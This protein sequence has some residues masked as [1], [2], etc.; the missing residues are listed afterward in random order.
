KNQSTGSFDKQL[1]EQLLAQNINL[2]LTQSEIFLTQVSNGNDSFDSQAAAQRL[3]FSNRMF[4]QALVNHDSQFTHQI[5]QDLEP[6]L[7]EHANGSPS[8]STQ[9][10]GNQPQVNQ[11]G[12]NWVSDNKATDLMFQIKAMKQQLSQKNDII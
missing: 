8:N 10:H 12:V 5:L 6:I 11:A 9:S 1:Q 2:H 7:L 4:K 3:L